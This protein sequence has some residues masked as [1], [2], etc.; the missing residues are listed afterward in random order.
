MEANS[1]TSIRIEA[2]V[3]APVDKVWNYWNQPEHVTQ[4]NNASEDWHTPK[5]E[6]DLRTGGA[7]TYRMEAKDGSFGFDFGG[8]YD[9][10]KKH[11]LISYTMSDGRKVKTT[12][13]A[14]GNTTRVTT[15]FD[16]ENE[17]PA[18]MQKQGWQAILNNFKAYTEK[19]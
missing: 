2:L 4:W 11:E 1:K 10:V 13:E 19:N 3:N 9:E 12:F 14:Q 15:V 18:E 7:F 8:I 16:A 5:A 17:N 6:N